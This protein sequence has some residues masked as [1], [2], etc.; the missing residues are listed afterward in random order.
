MIK[1]PA[2]PECLPAVREVLA[3][4][5]N[6]NIT[7]IFS[8]EIYVQVAEAYLSALEARLANGLRID[9]IASVASFFVSRVDALVEKKFEAQV[10][11]GKAQEHDRSKF[12]GK[13]GIAN[14]KLAY[15]AFENLFLSER[16]KKLSEAGARVQRPLWASTGTKNP[17]FKAVM[18]VE[19][20]AGRS[21]VNTMPPATVKAL[22]TDGAI[23]PKL[24]QGLSESSDLL[25]WIESQGIS[26]SALLSEL[27]VAGVKSFADSYRD[28]LGSIESKRSQV[29]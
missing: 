14:S 27:Q 9:Q 12:F 17:A 2:T 7:L 4:G 10:A 24:H 15:E 18:Y 22:L 1:I 16:F 28:L 8:R 25:T 19:E 5:I 29:A 23:S 3:E 20:L 26:M 11:A 6:V 21:T 13:V